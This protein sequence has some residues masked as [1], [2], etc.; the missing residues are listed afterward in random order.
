[1]LVIPAIDIMEG[2][3]VR[4]RQGRFEE[5]TVYSQDPAG[6]ALAWQKAGAQLI[7]VVDLDGARTGRIANLEAIRDIINAIDIPIQ[8]GGGVRDVPTIEMLFGMGVARVIVGSLAYKSPGI[9]AGLVPKYPGRIIGGIDARGGL[10]AIAGWQETTARSARDL[11]SELFDMGIGE[12]VFTDIQRDGMFS[13]PNL[14]AIREVASSGVRVIASGGISSLDDIRA[15]AA[16]RG[17][18][19]VGMII[20]KALY[21]GKFRLEDAIKAANSDVSKEDNTLP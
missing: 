15:I 5:K 14:D 17:C 10:V 6:T 20:G 16:L 4:L 13:G 2:K 8:V 9:L 11:A 18:G 21:A 3:C 12:V 1:M 7:H 19:V